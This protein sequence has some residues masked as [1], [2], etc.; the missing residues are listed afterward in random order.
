MGTVYMKEVGVKQHMIPS[1]FWLF[2][3]FMQGYFKITTSNL[4]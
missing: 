3:L 1:Y 2:W 4:N